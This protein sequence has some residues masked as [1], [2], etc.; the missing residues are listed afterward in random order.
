MFT[1]IPA[2]KLAEKAVAATVICGALALGTG[3]VAF[4][5]TT[6]AGSTP[7]ATHTKCAR[8][9]KALSKI[10]K[11]EAAIT[12]RISKLQADETKLTA[13]GHT[14]LAAKVET[15]INQLKKADTKAGSLA[16]KIE[17]KCPTAS[18]S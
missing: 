4:A 18:P 13:K 11:V 2:M 15:R 17:N 10:T 8:A 9:P 12:K 16:T 3:G 5:T 7:A 1:K 14:K 6:T